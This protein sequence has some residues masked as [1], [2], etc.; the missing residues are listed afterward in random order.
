MKSLSTRIAIH[1]PTGVAAMLSVA[2]ACSSTGLPATSQVSY[3]YAALDF[4]GATDSDWSDETVA[5]E[6]GSSAVHLAAQGARLHLASGRAQVRRL[7]RRFEAQ[8][9]RGKRVQ[10]DVPAAFQG[11]EAA[12][13][14]AIRLSVEGTGKH[15]DAWSSSA[16]PRVTRDTKQVL[17]AA[18]DVPGDATALKIELQ[19]NGDAEA[20]FESPQLSTTT[21]S[22]PRRPLTDDTR[23]ALRSFAQLVGY[24][25]FFHPSDAA[26]RL[27][28][29]GFEADVVRRLLSTQGRTGLRDV[30]RDVVA[31]VAPTAWLNDDHPPAERGPRPGN[32]LKLTRWSRT[33]VRN[34]GVYFAF[35]TEISESRDVGIGLL[36]TAPSRGCTRAT[37]RVAADIDP[38][39]PTL[40]LFL[41][42]LRGSGSL[43]YTSQPVDPAGAF[44]AEIPAEATHVG[45]GARIGGE[46]GI[47]LKQLELVCDSTKKVLGAFS[48]GEEPEVFGTGA[49]LY[50]VTHP[51]EC[52]GC[53]RVT[54]LAETAYQP[55]RDEIDVEI[56]F[57]LRLH[58]PLAVWTDGQQTFPAQSAPAAGP[59]LP[60][61]DPAVRIASAIDIWATLRW[62][63]PYFDELHVDWDRALGEALDA[64]AHARSADELLLALERMVGALRDDH[65][66]VY[67]GASSNGVLPLV[68]HQIDAKLVFVNG[69]GDYKATFPRGSIL[70]A[71]DDVPAG[72]AMEKLAS[73]ISAATPA[74]RDAYL[75]FALAEGLAGGLVTVRVKQPDGQFAAVRI[76]RLS[77]AKYIRQLREDHPETGT[78]LAPGVYYVDLATL[79][80]AAWKPLPAKLSS[81]RAILCDARNGASQTA[82]QILAHFIDH[83]IKSPYWD[84]PIALP[85][86]KRYARTQSTIYPSEPRLT[87][88]LIFLTSGLSASS[89]ETI[90]QYAHAAGLGT[91]I[92]EPTGG[93]NGDVTSFESL[94][95]LTIRFT[96]LRT[97]NPDGSTFH[98]RG[99]APDVVVHPTLAGLRAGRDE[100]L[101]AALARATA[102]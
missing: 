94:G 25:R 45:Y 51:S 34:D 54:R 88:K 19:V 10:L 44:G 86:E 3:A 55:A 76:P 2:L 28:W 91:V 50:S 95:G 33:G 68:F 89:P 23:S 64:S 21:A 80:D 22:T 8:A 70:D 43:S 4:T 79:D 36:K 24:L 41:L 57:G 102:P 5:G 39:A 62:F 20:W 74:W 66:S 75:P 87:A 18:L 1:S 38:G 11:H 47:D 48:S 58:M 15:I 37:V 93:T 61:G 65:A 90:L 49:H 67:H 78:E 73:T 53:T 72:A 42:P 60:P 32:G 9:L 27:D 99:I 71:I 85:T 101:E 63:Y 30:L 6:P 12:A 14:A 26:A 56:G 97:L 84:K 31:T 35:R 40:E 81:G 92:G 59:P 98:G 29:P 96:G 82:F 77:R 100:I 69:I 7:T 13:F 17:R 46:G 52:P 16:S 83:P